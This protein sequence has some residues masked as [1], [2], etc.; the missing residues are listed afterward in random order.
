MPF[1]SSPATLQL[2]PSALS[3][4]ASLVFLCPSVSVAQTPGCVTFPSRKVCPGRELCDTAHSVSDPVDPRGVTAVC[5]RAYFCLQYLKY[6]L[7]ERSLLSNTYTC[8]TYGKQASAAGL[9]GI[10]A[11][12]VCILEILGHSATSWGMQEF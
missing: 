1:W 7:Y 3:L 9:P 4:C 5:P 2:S 12:L 11:V 10:S 8:Q 6:L